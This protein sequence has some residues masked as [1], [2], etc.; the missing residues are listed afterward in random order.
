MISKKPTVDNWLPF[1]AVAIA[2]LALTA[3]VWQGYLFRKHNQLSVR[4]LL[5]IETETKKTV[6]F[7][8]LLMI[9]LK[10][11]GLGPAIINKHTVELNGEE[12]SRKKLYQLVKGG[13]CSLRFVDFK[14]LPKGTIVRPGDSIS[15]LVVDERNLHCPV[16]DFKE[17]YRNF[18]SV[19]VD[20]QYQS[21]YEEQITLTT[22]L[23]N[24]F[25]ELAKKLATA[26]AK[27]RT[28]EQ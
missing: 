14:I 15:I 28:V 16:G 17:G 27:N 4:P 24:T 26:D 3:S 2:A 23:F 5:A 21:L 20:V 8:T 13:L 11:G 25:P 6:V 1:F 9:K 7:G 12:L 18:L 10:N 22:K 19:L